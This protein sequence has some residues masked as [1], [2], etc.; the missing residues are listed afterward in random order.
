MILSSRRKRI[1]LVSFLLLSHLAIAG[2]TIWNRTEKGIEL[3]SHGQRIRVEAITPT[4][5]RVTAIPGSECSLKKSPIVLEQPAVKWRLN[6][7]KED[8]EL[9]TSGVVA[10]IGKATGAVRFYERDGNKLLEEQETGGRVFTPARVQEKGALSI[11]Q[12]FSLGNDEALYGLGQFQ[13]GIMNWRNQRVVLIQRNMEVSIPLLVS[14]NHYGIYWDNYSFTEFQSV[15]KGFSFWS[16]VGDQIDYY[17]IQGRTIDSVIAG[18]R[19]LTGAVPMLPR[20]AYGFWQSKE[21]YHSRQEVLSVAAEYRKRRVPIDVIVQDWQ[22]WGR[23]G[24]SSMLWDDSIYPDPKS[25]LDSLHD[26]YHCRMMI[27]V[28]P[29]VAPASPVGEELDRKGHLFGDAKSWNTG[30]IYDTYSPE[31][32][33]IYWKHLRKGLFSVGV[34][35][36]WLDATEPEIAWASNQLESRQ[37]II[38]L[39]EN[40]LGSFVRYLNTYPFFT[41]R[42]VYE[43]QRMDT[44]RKRV[45]IL[46]RSAFA[47]QQRTGA[48]TWSGDI[49]SSYSVLKNQISGGLNFS[50]AGNPYWNTDIGGFFPVGSSGGYPAGVKDSAYRELYVRW[51]QFGTFCPIMRSHGTGTPREIWQFGEPGTWAYDAILRFDRLRYRL[52]PY[53]YSNAWSISSSGSTLMRALVMDFPSDPGVL[54]VGDEYLFGPALLAAPVTKEIYYSRE[55]PAAAIPAPDLIDSSG[56]PGGLTAAYYEG[57]NL[58]TLAARVRDTSV[59]FNWI[60]SKSPAGRTFDFSARWSGYL[61]PEETG[62]HEIMLTSDD[63]V[64]LRMNDSL[65]I[66]NWSEHSGTVDTYRTWLEA[67][68]RYRICLEYFQASGEALVVLGWRMPSEL[69][70]TKTKTIND[71]V[72]VYLPRGASWFDFWTGERLAGGQL[73]PRKV[74]I[75]LMPLYVRSGSV[76]PM[77]PEMQY[78]SEKPGDTLEVRIYPGA[79]G[80]ITIYDD[81]GD[82]YDYEK[83]VY[84]TIDLRWNDLTRT[85][86]IGER[87]G[88]FPGMLHD[89]TFSI[90]LV[91][92]GKGAGV[93]PT[94]KSDSVVGYRGNKITVKL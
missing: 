38:G 86:E 79:D 2:Q 75:D 88:S 80:S 52:L 87:K 81:G 21:R 13:D 48:I 27:S 26:Q 28:W 94:L 57:K 54:N 22:Y 89:R 82:G 36:W 60:N 35:G 17:F 92:G 71:T 58:D 47:G 43:H 15:G 68:K 72:T 53:I 32:N 51:F 67:G 91:A 40:A 6:E 50:L 19:R 12:L 63:G 5:I 83:G 29:Q 34:D 37:N 45:V 41:T 30:W 10:R 9:I 70:R 3:Q 46:T 55:M 62:V 42:G 93:E 69:A 16:E 59:N 56:T 84:S 23:H 90:V 74:P 31:A 7:S 44:D 77:G 20:W 18:Y 14:T 76:L 73:V 33:D 66:D 49:S 61:L 25:M 39:G 24:W 1:T 11:K 78:S 4:I 85:L 65:V 8:L 64:R